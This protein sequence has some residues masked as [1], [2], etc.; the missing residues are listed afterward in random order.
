MR[1]PLLLLPPLIDTDDQRDIRMAEMWMVKCLDQ[2]ARYVCL[3]VIRPEFAGG[4]KWETYMR[5]VSMRLGLSGYVA[6]RDQ[7]ELDDDL[8]IEGEEEYYAEED[9]EH[10]ED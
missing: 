4:E 7:D 1:R 5:D 6:G 10:G 9:P 2:H 8:E 3:F